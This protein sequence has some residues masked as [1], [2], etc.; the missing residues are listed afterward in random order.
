[1]RVL[2]VCSGIGA[3][4]CAWSSLGW[5]SIAVAEIDAFPSAVL[6]HRFPG[7]P[8]CGDMTKFQEWPDA[9]VDVLVGGT[10][11][12]SFSVAGLR[13]GLADPRGN[14][15]LTYLAI[16]DRYRPRWLVWENV[17]GVRSSLSHSAPDKRA[18]GIDLDGHDGPRDGEEVVVVDEYETHEEHA[19]GCFLAGLS[20]LGYGWAYRSMDA[21][22]AGVA[23]R[24]ERV[25]VVGCLG[26][27]RGAAAVLFERESLSGHPAP[28]REA[29]EGVAGTLAGGARSSGGYSEDDIPHVAHCLNAKGGGGRIDGESE[30]FVATTLRARDGAKGVD[31]DCTDTLVPVAYRTSGNCGAWETGATTDA[32]TTATDPN[33]HV[34]AFSCKDHGADAGHISPTLRSMG[35]DGSHA[36][37]GGQV[38]VASSMAVRRLLPVECEK[39]QGFPRGWTDIPYRGKPAADGPRYRA[40]GNSMAVPVVRWLGERIQMVDDL[41]REIAARN[42]A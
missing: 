15:A 42:A 38:A 22:Y 13:G 11:C 2:S 6:A 32:V 33:H 10:P 27:W 4:E 12:Q 23:Q 9:D 21:Q 34:L 3:P 31:S 35:H 7:V 20:E 28:R 36:N 18:P 40:L 29:R 30:T 5:Q 24:R 25:F 19:F 17:P 41:M 39:L 1:M 8:N 14:L 16:A 26:D 37:A